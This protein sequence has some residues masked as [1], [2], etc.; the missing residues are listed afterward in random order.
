MVRCTTARGGE[1]AFS[2]ERKSGTTCAAKEG[3][4][5]GTMGSATL[6]RLAL[7]ATALL[8]SASTAFAGAPQVTGRAYVVQNGVTGEV[9]AHSHDR[10]QLPIASITKLMTVLV[11]LQHSRLDDVVTVSGEPRG[12]RRVVDLP[13]EGRAV[14]R[15]GAGRGER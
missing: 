7:L 10:E 3:A 12:G 15:P 13:A 14:H 8:L 1:T 6:R 9:L 5:G 4:R 11:A 2:P